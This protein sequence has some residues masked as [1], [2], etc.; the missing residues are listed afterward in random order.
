MVAGDHP[1]LDAGGVRHA[2]IVQRAT[3]YGYDNRYAL[4]AAASALELL[5]DCLGLERAEPGGRLA[6]HT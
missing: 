1:H 4:D 5:A 3:L 6:D 2:C